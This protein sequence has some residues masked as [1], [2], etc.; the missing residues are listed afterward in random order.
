MRSTILLVL[1]WGCF[2]GMGHTQISHNMTLRGQYKVDTLPIASGTRYNEVWGY[3]DCSGR[4]YAILGS[5]HYVHFFDLVDLANPKEIEA[6]PGGATTI[7]R[8]MKTYK[9]RAYSVC[10]NCQ[11]GLM[12]FD[13]SQ[14]P[15]T[16]VKTNQTTAFFKSAHNIF[17]DEEA[18]WL[19][20][21]GSNANSN[22]AIILDLNGDP[23]NPTLIG[24]PILPAGYFHDIYVR[25]KIG[26]C[27]HGNNGFYVYDFSNPQSPVLLGTLTSYPQ[28]GYNHSSWLSEDGNYAVMADETFN[29]GLK[30]L[31]VSNLADIQVT[32]VFRSKLLAPVDTASIPH[33]PFIREN[34]IFV[35]YYHD[36]VQVFDMSDPSDVKQVAWYDT[37]PANSNYFDYK[38]CWG[39]YAFL[40]SGTILGSDMSNG[41]FVLTLDSIDLAPVAVPAYPDPGITLTGDSLICAGESVL[42]AADPNVSSLEWYLD[43]ELLEWVDPQIQVQEAG[44]YTATLHDAYCETQSDS[45]QVQVQAAPEPLLTYT[46]TLA[47]LG[48][49]IQLTANEELDTWQWLLDGSPIE[50]ATQAVWLADASGQYGYTGVLGPCMVS[51][52]NVAIQIVEAAVPSISLVNDTLFATPAES[53]QWFLNDILLEGA[54]NPYFVPG[55]SGSYSVQ[56]TDVNGCDALSA[57]LEV[58]VINSVSN[59]LPA[60]WK[61]Y[62]NPARSWLTIELPGVENGRYALYD[63]MGRMRMKAGLKGEKT[64]I[65]LDGLAPGIYFLEIQTEKNRMLEK[66]FVIRS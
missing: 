44:W 14:L 11:E 62:P 6:F 54:T 35:S 37:Y 20:V 13:L 42:L 48:D 55:E 31:N 2:V 23:D 40:P 18:G 1:L 47:C 65:G 29:K 9:Q 28:S 51:S 34:Y 16:V 19:F 63:L 60:G 41:L 15:D 7:W 26:Y 21:A 56:I 50:G 30:M 22:G 24:N 25:N 3:T 66:V 33:N 59:Q 46:D 4:E 64:E 27:S 36:G 32:D 52:E 39:V 8:D 45:V 57:S 58:E 17:I 10:D 61:I 53:Y 5:A 12:I 49:S 38:G 43:G